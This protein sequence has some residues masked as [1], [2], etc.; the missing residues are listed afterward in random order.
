MQPPPVKNDQPECWPSLM[1]RMLKGSPLLPL[2]Q[3]RHELGIERYGV[4][5]Q[6][7]N[8]RDAVQD[9]LEEALDLLV[10]LEQSRLENPKE[11]WQGA[12][13]TAVLDVAIKLQ[14]VYNR[15]KA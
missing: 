2:M 12:C 13:Q 4:G 15:R 14:Y 7:H 3:A 1:K 10:Y 8:G 6:P 5:L 11:H 9:A